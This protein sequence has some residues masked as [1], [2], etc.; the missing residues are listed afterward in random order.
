MSPERALDLV[1]LEGGRDPGRE[2]VRDHLLERGPEVPGHRGG[3]RPG[4]RAGDPGLILRLHRLGH[5]AAHRRSHHLRDGGPDLRRHV[6]REALEHASRVARGERADTVRPV[7]VAQRRERSVEHARDEIA[8][9]GLHL[10]RGD[11]LLDPLLV[12]RIVHGAEP[13]LDRHRR[14]LTHDRG[15]DALD[16]G[17]DQGD[18]RARGRRDGECRENA[19]QSGVQRA[20]V[21]HDPPQMSM[22]RT[23]AAGTLRASICP[24]FLEIRS[25][26]PQVILRRDNLPHPAEP[27]PA[28]EP[29]PHREPEMSRARGLVLDD[30]PR[31]RGESGAS[32]AQRGRRS[33]QSSI[34]IEPDSRRKV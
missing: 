24:H 14:G 1:F 3:D 20:A 19:N 30:S 22:E 8:L 11:H 17:G 28:D 10:G 12:G 31:L 25:R 15:V 2:V 23:R 26:A 13:G 7:P 21:A 29:H 16:P 34:S 4:D 18:T 6:A 5:G 32:R 33:C 27:R 9:D